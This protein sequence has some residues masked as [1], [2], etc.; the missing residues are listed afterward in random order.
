MTGKQLSGW[1]TK[2]GWTQ[3][4]AAAWWGCTKRTWQRYESGDLPI[5]DPMDTRIRDPY[6]D[7]AH[8]VGGKVPIVV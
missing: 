8:I 3:E 1:R 4:Q 5:P 6:H 2:R 7:S